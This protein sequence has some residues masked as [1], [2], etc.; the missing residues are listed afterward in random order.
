MILA[1]ARITEAPL[2]TA[3]AAIHD[4]ALVETIWD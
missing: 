3:D 2:I 1:A 4:A